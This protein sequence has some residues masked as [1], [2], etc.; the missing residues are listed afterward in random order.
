MDLLESSVYNAHIGFDEMGS[1][2]FSVRY[3]VFVH[4]LDRCVYGRLDSGS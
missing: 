2:V 3:I 1:N 4:P